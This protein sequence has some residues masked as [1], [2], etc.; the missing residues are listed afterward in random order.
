MI[1][2]ALT[3]FIIGAVLDWMLGDPGWLPHPI[4]GIGLLIRRLETLLRRIPHERIA[5]CLLVCGVLVATVSTVVLS[6]QWAGIIAA[7]YWIFT[8]LAV[9][10][11]DRESHEVI[12]AL[13]RGDLDQAR[14]LVGRLVGRDTND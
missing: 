3:A 1:H 2:A 10:S 8:S 7:T 9:R 11:L 14:A 13:R 4:R 5:G 6:L 12:E